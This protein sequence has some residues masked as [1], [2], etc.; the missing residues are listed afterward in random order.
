AGFAGLAFFLSW[1]A[2]SNRRLLITNQ[3]AIQKPS[4][5]ARYRQL[6]LRCQ[7][8]SRV[9]FQQFFQQQHSDYRWNAPLAHSGTSQNLAGHGGHSQKLVCGKFGMICLHS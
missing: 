4:D 2:D 6:H 1:R 7:E 9:L 3:Q 5:S 8:K